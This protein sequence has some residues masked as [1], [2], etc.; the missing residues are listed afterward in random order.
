M[1]GSLEAWGQDTQRAYREQYI[2]NT[3]TFA[4][5]IGLRQCGGGP[6]RRQCFFQQLRHAQNDA[7]VGVPMGLR[8]KLTAVAPAGYQAGVLLANI[9]SLLKS[10]GHRRRARAAQGESG[11]HGCGCRPLRAA[12]FRGFPRAWCRA[13]LRQ[14]STLASPNES[15]PKLLVHSEFLA[16]N[17]VGNR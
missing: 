1:A 8:L 13:P 17:R 6:Q 2:P 3:A 10:A 14:G 15:Q 9:T 11:A 4:P 12:T 7:S 5:S 16:F